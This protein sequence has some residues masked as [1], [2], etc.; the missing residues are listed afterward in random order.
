MTSMCSLEKS[1]STAIRGNFVN[2]FTSR[3]FKLLLSILALNIAIPCNL[4][5]D[6]VDDFAL[7]CDKIIANYWARVKFLA[8]AEKNEIAPSHVRENISNIAFYTSFDAAGLLSAAELTTAEIGRDIDTTNTFATEFNRLAAIK[9]FNLENYQKL[10]DISLRLRVLNKNLPMKATELQSIYNSLQLGMKQF[11]GFCERESAL[12]E[13]QK[14]PLG[15]VPLLSK[16]NYTY[17]APNEFY[18]DPVAY[19]YAEI[20]GLA[21]LAAGIAIFIYLYGLDALLASLSLEAT[22]NGAKL[23]FTG[24]SAYIPMLVIIVA[25]AVGNY[26]EHQ[27]NEARKQKA[28][29][30]YN[31]LVRQ[32]EEA[33]IWFEQNRLQDSE[34]RPLALGE[35]KRNELP[36]NPKTNNPGI[37]YDLKFKIETQSAKLKSDIASENLLISKV[38]DNIK[39]LNTLIISYE[40]ELK[41][42]IGAGAFADH[43]AKTISA[44][45]VTLSWD[46]YNQ[47]IKPLWDKFQTFYAANRTD[48]IGLYDYFD[49]EIKTPANVSMDVVIE[50]LKDDR[51]K[52]SPDFIQ[53][54]QMKNELLS[55]IELKVNRCV[56]KLGA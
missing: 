16:P 4:Y 30:A 42:T 5:A 49:Q 33:K 39:K 12:L 32:I 20:A 43:K 52:D 24:A 9:P 13:F 53:M 8:S 22:T 34:F 31:N 23:G 7:E 38:D 45:K 6:G 40:N 46:I 35:C 10:I 29:K 25:I 36:I 51:N 21:T 27:E 18:R 28:R 14:T 56:A 55:G 2:I 41:L 50:A 54:N 48:C 26:I 15:P 19:A 37:L 47:Q 11:E 17:I 44:S 1:K 3:G